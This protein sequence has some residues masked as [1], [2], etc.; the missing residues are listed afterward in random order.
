MLNGRL[1]FLKVMEF[2]FDGLGL[3]FLSSVCLYSNSI[4]LKIGLYPPIRL[5]FEEY[6]RLLTGTKCKLTLEVKAHVVPLPILK[7]LSK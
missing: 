1:H 4:S 6:H 2:K 3:P 5:P 7:I